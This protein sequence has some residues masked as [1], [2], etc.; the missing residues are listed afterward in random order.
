MNNK[1][2][3]VPAEQLQEERAR[4]ARPQVRL[5]RRPAGGLGGR[6]AFEALF[7]DETD[8]SKAPAQ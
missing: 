5:L 2:V 3:V 6:L 8:P 4:A 1:I 7:K